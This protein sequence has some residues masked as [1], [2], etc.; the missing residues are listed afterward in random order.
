[1]AAPAGGPTLSP[2]VVNGASFQPGISPGSWFTVTGSNFA[3]AGFTGDWSASIV[4]G[5]LPTVLNGVSIDIGGKPAY[6]NFVS[7]GQINAVAPDVGDGQV[8][9]KVTTPGGTTNTVNTTSQ[10][11]G[12][13]FFL[14]PGNQAVATRQDF[15]WAVKAGT[16]T[17]T[18]TS[19]AK[20]GDV[21]ILWGT[22][23]GPANPAVPSGIQTPADRTYNAANGVKVTLGN[24]AATVFGAAL[25]PGFAGLYQIGIQVP[26]S[27]AD[28]DWPLKAN[29]GS[30]QSPDGVVLSVKR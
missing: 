25:A 7:P 17:G 5:K 23:F 15:S 3:P 19:A 4:D 21:I 2:D 16:F 6:I 30:F 13:A 18:G 27:I 9:I 22:G 11:F 8:A 28:G 10:Q 1:V 29:I 12:P 26:A 24:T 20:P 14:W